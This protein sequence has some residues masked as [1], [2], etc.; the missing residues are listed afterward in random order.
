MLLSG[1]ADLTLRALSECFLLTPSLWFV[2]AYLG[3]YILSPLL[4][5][6]AEKAS[7]RQFK[8]LLILFFTFQT[9][10]GCTYS[11]NWIHSGYSTFSFIGLYL[12]AS[13]MRT[14]DIPAISRHG[15]TIYL[16]AAL[17]NSIYYYAKVNYNLPLDAFSYINPIVIL[18]SIGLFT[19]FSK[20]KIKHSVTINY[21]AASVFAVYLFHQN[22]YI[23]PIFK[24][25]VLDLYNSYSGVICIIIILLFDIGVFLLA[26]LLDQP[27]KFIWKKLNCHLCTLVDKLCRK[28]C[29]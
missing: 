3:L 6:F 27:R 18:G 22:T 19:W 8:I 11:V 10:Y 15:G 16:L 5:V 23:K 26:I 9:V 24:S 1:K 17:V 25:T 21:V 13:Y 4:N 12:L 20:L 7:R 2:K 28:V 29:R 14:Y